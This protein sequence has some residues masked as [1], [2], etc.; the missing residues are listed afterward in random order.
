VT[1][2]LDNRSA[3]QGEPG[4][5]ALV[6]GVSLYPHLPG[7]AESAAPDSYGMAQLTS[8]ALT[9]FRFAEWLRG[10]DSDLP[11]PLASIR[12]LVSAS[13]KEVEVEPALAGFGGDPTSAELLRVAK[14]WREDVASHRDNVATFYFAGHGIKETKDNVILVLKD[15]GDGV[16]G[17]LR[18]A[19]DTDSLR[20]GMAP[21]EARPNIARRQLYFVDACRTYPASLRNFAQLDWTR[22]FDVEF[23]EL[24]DDRKDPVFFAAV[25]GS[26]AYGLDGEPTLF[27]Q[28]LFTCLDGGAGIL[29]EIE[30]EERWHVTISSLS[31]ALGTVLDG[32]NEDEGADQEFD[33]G[34]SWRAPDAPVV[35]LET[36]P[37]VNVRIT[38]E[39]SE[40]V[41][42]IRLEVLDRTG[43][44]LATPN[45]LEPHPYECRWPAGYYAFNAYPAPP[46]QP[47]V[48]VLRQVF[49]PS[50]DKKIA[51]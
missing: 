23:T 51:L 34:G 5:H 2:V 21:T 30:G 11:V 41:T 18:N 16:G 25:P 50:Y 27:S 40:A 32:L 35:Y 42:N 33:T 6:V 7:G 45:P 24:A 17:A 13:A 8:P 47:S 43:Q 1:L 3:R 9:A 48:D 36:P 22:V 49:P 20:E 14:D 29:A 12:A 10:H 31:R 38:L 44:V 4:M 26:T 39:P 46:G 28:A 37:E 19:V 15:F